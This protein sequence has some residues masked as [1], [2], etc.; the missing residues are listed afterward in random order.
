MQ[1]VIAQAARCITGGFF[2]AGVFLTGCASL[3]TDELLR[4]NSN[5]PQRVE[6]THVPFIA[7]QAY[8]CGPASL[9][10]MLQAQSNDVTAEALLAQVYVPERQGSLQIEMLAAARKYQV[11]PYVLDKKMSDLLAEIRAQ[12]PVL[13]MQN[14][15]LSWL[16]KWHYAVVIGYDFNTAEMILRSGTEPRHVVAMKVFERTWARSDYWA[17]VILAP[18]RLPVTATEQRYVESVAALE[19][20]KNYAVS[21]TAYQTALKRWPN[22]LVAMMGLANTDY[23]LQNY[24][25]AAEA[26]K[27]ITQHYPQSADAYNNLADSLL[28]LQRYEEAR[29]A[30]RIA[31]SLGGAQ[32]AI[33]LQTLSEVEQLMHTKGLE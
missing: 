28:Q 27:N 6:L 13:V 29:A 3:Q 31:V 1:A 23:A 25:A 32:R 2:I 20:M 22:N 10:M 15:G 17:V 33:Y 19:R 21:Q 24:A 4:A 26:F 18:D 9:A 14:L 5:S 30:A 12:H 11:V 7:Q 16:P 8:Q